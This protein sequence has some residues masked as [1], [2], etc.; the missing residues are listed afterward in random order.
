[1]ACVVPGGQP[2]RVTVRIEQ[3]ESFRQPAWRLWVAEARDGSIVPEHAIAAAGREVRDRDL[4]IVRRQFDI[5]ACVID[6]P[7]L[8]LAEPVYPL[9][10]GSLKLLAD[11]EG[12][13][14]NVAW[15]R[16]DRGKASLPFRKQLVS[17][18]IR[19]AHRARR[20]R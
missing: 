18:R 15:I 9:A 17:V 10:P 12:V 6:M 16:G 2:A 20:Q 11:K 8:L 19:E 1:A 4:D 14:I 5:P 13:G 3:T 7:I